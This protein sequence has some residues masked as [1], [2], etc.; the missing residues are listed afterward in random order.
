[1]YSFMYHKP[2][3]LAQARACFDAAE[4]AAYLSGGHTLIPAMKSRLSAPS[5]LIDLGKIPVLHGISI[6]GPHLM[7][8]A[9]ETHAKVAASDVA[10]RVIAALPLLAGSIGDVQVRYRGTLGGSVANNDPAADYPSAVL[11]LDAI[12]ETSDQKITADDYFDGLY[13][14]TLEPGE[15]LT[16]ISFRIPIASGYAKM[17]N[18]ASRYA[19]A[20]TFVARYEDGVRVAITGAGGDGVFRWTAAEKALSTT[21]D[22][23][24]LN[25][26]A[27]DSDAM[28]SDMHASKDFRS[29]LA[30]ICTQRAVANMGKLTL[31]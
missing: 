15:I 5:D 19:L 11:A 14:T 6:V 13:T 28:F 4:D 21:F 25:D 26:L 12:I 31:G 30:K 3:E 17:R 24:A 1:M 27:L 7:I 29:H 16:Q 2:L 8:G 22:P 10:A 9:A 23:S 18:P 20:A